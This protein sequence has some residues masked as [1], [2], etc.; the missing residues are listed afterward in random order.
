MDAPQNW[1][2]IVARYDLRIYSRALPD[3]EIFALYSERDPAEKIR[4]AA[5]A[6][7]ASAPG[8]YLV[9]IH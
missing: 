2:H 8:A 5:A 9:R 7:S 4:A 6:I 1:V 3:N